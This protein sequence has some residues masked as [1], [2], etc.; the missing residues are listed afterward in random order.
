MNSPSPLAALQAQAAAALQSGDLRAAEA[1]SLRLLQANPLDSQA[2]LVMAGVLAQRD[3]HRLACAA[4]L[5]AAERMGPQTLPH[6]AAVTLRLIATGEYERALQVIRKVDPRRV[7]VAPL[8]VEFSQQLS[9]LEEHAL[10]LQYMDAALALGLQAESIGFLRGNLLKFL[11]RLDEAAESYE[12]SL[13]INPGYAY[14]HWA[15]AYLGLP[16]DTLA[17]AQRVRGALASMPPGHADR[18][19]L[20]Y[21][22]FKELDAAGDVGAAWS[23][24]EDGARL[25]RAQVQY[26]AGLEGRLFDALAAATGPGFLDDAT[27]VDAGVP[28][29]VFVLG[30]PRTGT[31]LLERILGG[32]GQVALCGELNDFRMQ[33]KWSVD[34]HSLGFLDEATIARLPGVDFAELGRRYLSHVAWRA[35]GAQ[36]FS[37]KNPGNFMLTGLIL[38]ALPQARIVHLRREPMDACFSNLKELFAANAHPYSYDLADLAAHHGHY[39]RLMAH[40]HAIAPGRILDVRYEDLVTE[41]E[42]QAR[43]VMQFCGLDYRD[44][45]TRVEANA[46]PVSTA[47]SAQVRQPIHARNVGGWRR[48]APQLE[49]LR[50]LLE[51]G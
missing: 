5:R 44:G 40:W 50:R 18:P 11:G 34:H 20:H 3:R 30:L 37:D 9:L 39:A 45:Q 32:S 38:K 15:L 24:L 13:A 49:P 33:L 28:V 6:I 8:L 27:A 2:N 4:A 29:P 1:A 47:S 51:T 43:R 16:G 22:L 35:P 7:P 48:Y 10:A 14:A 26:D 42:A 17:R 19:Y 31:T 25:R 46:A 23:A 21:A 12:R 41:P 36:H